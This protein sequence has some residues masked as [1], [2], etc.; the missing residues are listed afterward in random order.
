MLVNTSRRGGG[1]P[2][3]MVNGKKAAPCR[4]IGAAFL[5]FI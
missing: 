4:K 5:I 1:R 2:E 3:E